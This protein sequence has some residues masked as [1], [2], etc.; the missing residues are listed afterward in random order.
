MYSFLVMTRHV[1]RFPMSPKTRNNLVGF[2]VN[3]AGLHRDCT[4][5]VNKGERKQ[6][7]ILKVLV[8]KMISDVF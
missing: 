6:S 3:L 2:V 4:L 1:A 8:S 7:G 5:P